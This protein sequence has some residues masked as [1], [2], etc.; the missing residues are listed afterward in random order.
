MSVHNFLAMSNILAKQ[1]KEEREAEEEENRRWE[2]S[3][4][5][6]NNSMPNFS[7]LSSMMSGFG[8]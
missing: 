6:I 8:I 2:N 3:L 1:L 4:P 7:S 5:N